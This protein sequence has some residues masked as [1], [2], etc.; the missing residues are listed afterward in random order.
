MG[1]E[2]EFGKDDCVKCTDFS[3]TPAHTT[4]VE[5]IQSQMLFAAILD[6][7]LLQG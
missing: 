5:L 3:G 4:V 1:V 6:E 2:A 7:C